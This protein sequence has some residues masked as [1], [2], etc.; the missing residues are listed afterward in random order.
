MH[1]GQDSRMLLEEPIIDGLLQFE[2][3]VHSGVVS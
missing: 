1:Y 2:A 3:P